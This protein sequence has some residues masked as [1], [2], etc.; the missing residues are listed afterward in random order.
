[1]PVKPVVEWEG[2]EPKCIETFQYD[3]DENDAIRIG[4]R[5]LIL[6]YLKCGMI[7]ALILF[8]PALLV[9]PRGGNAG[10]YAL[11][12]CG[13]AVLACGFKPLGKGFW[14][15]LREYWPINLAML[16]LVGAIALHQASNGHFIGKTYDMPSRLALFPLI[17]WGLL[18]LSANELKNVQWGLVLGTLTGTGALYLLTAAG[19]TRPA[20]VLTT[21]IIPFGNLTFLMGTL[22][23]FSVGWNRREDKRTILVKA[24]AGAAGL[25]AAYLSQTRGSWIAVPVFAMIGYAMTTS[26]RAGHKLVAITVV[27]A[28]LI[29]F[30]ASSDTVRARVREARS[31]ISSYVDGTNRDTSVGIR[32]QLWRGAWL[33]FT[34]HPYFGVGLE[35]Y[36]DALKELEARNVITPMAA[37]FHHAHN[38]I[39]YNMA[40]LGVF[41]MAAVL[42]LYFVPIFY[43]T[44]AIRH[45]DKEL[46]TIAG[47]GLV[48]AGGFFIFGLTEVMFFYW[49]VNHTF[50]SIL[51]A[52]MFAHL[53]K[54]KAE[55]SMRGQQMT[56][57]DRANHLLQE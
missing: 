16:G 2:Q 10:F 35:R 9:L 31:D 39:L 57:Q 38:E 55:L 4:S 56:S 46:R 17:F 36:T 21:P 1:M 11:L 47:M 53:V 13:L 15:I 34:E 42:A 12:L 7:A 33:L 50:Y 41:G 19:T 32:F 40:T 43:F 25:Y 18:V 14:A 45:P 3:A 5:R 51:L 6:H 44:R 37:T 22:A 24:L 49:T 26:L 29:G 27:F 8:L 30:S 20:V 54:R 23:L 28:M 48:L 52:V